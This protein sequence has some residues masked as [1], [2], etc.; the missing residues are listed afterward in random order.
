[1]SDIRRDHEKSFSTLKS[2]TIVLRENSKDDDENYHPKR[3]NLTRSNDYSNS[4]RTSNLD[5]KVYV[6]N[7]PTNNITDSELLNFFKTFGKVSDI[8][9][10]KDYLFVQ[11][12]R[13]EDARTLTKEGQTNLILKGNKLDVLP[14]MDTSSKNR[15]LSLTERSSQE[16]KM[17][18]EE[19]SRKSRRH[20]DYDRQTSNY[21]PPRKRYSSKNHLD[22]HHQ[23]K[24]ILN[25]NNNSN[26]YRNR[27]Y[28]FF[29]QQLIDST[30]EKVSCVPDDSV[31]V[32][33]HFTKTH[34]T[35]LLI[36]ESI[37]D[38][39]LS[40]AQEKLK[41]F[42]SAVV[43]NADGFLSLE[44]FE[45]FL[46]NL[47]IEMNHEDVKA[48]FQ[49]INPKNKDQITF[50]EFYQY[51]AE[52]IKAEKAMHTQSEL[53]LLAACLKAD[54]EGTCAL[55]G[56][57]QFINKRWENFN[58][59]KRHGK[60]GKLV[61]VG[62]DQVKD[63]LPGEYSLVDLIAWSDIQPQDIR[64]RFVKISDVRWTK[65]TEP[66]S[67]S[68]SLLLPSNFTDLRLPIEIATNDNLA[69][70]GCCLANESQMKVSLLH[71]HAIQ[72]FTY[73]ENYY[74]EFV[75]GRAGLEKHEFAHLDCPF[76]EDSGFFIL[77]KFL[78]QNENELHLT[79]F[80]IPLK[81]TIYVPPLTIHSNDYLQG[82]WR[83]MLS[84][85]AD[86]DHVIIERERYNGTRDQ[87]SFDFM[88]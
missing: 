24:S 12:D 84:D 27:S 20:S 14:A 78:E 16:Y 82:T 50:Q 49:E 29:I 83:T 40:A 67:S 13:I 33:E 79:A 63:V 37:S 5:A 81:H 1:M 76:Q 43:V 46:S 19:S 87:I 9:V 10:Y 60:T 38:Q 11:Y 57:S 55:G 68:G 28:Q 39:N 18:E 8:R 77:G 86:I 17:F 73:H 66:K 22:D 26:T 25:N 72:D 48:L 64:P 59:F 21:E 69:Y 61:M 32:Y 54:R 71:R 45:K 74:N 36:P 44:E 62:S 47:N 65:S 35:P 56:I 52:M 41:V 51:Y 7:I 53:A 58:N 4:Q 30:L 23:Q 80:K 88:N 70:Y 75:K 6:G 34:S 31:T 42:F 15:K 2:S 3:V 85:A